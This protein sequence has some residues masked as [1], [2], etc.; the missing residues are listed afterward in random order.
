MTED[1]GTSSARLGS[2]A[3]SVGED[4][5]RFASTHPCTAT[6]FVLSGILF[7]VLPTTVLVNLHRGMDFSDAGYYYASI[8]QLDQ[9]GM[10]TTQFGT[11][12]NL[13]H[14]PES[15]VI[16]RAVLFLLLML[17]GA[18]LS[19]SIIRL[20]EDRFQDPVD[21]AL[22]TLCSISAVATFYVHW[23]P[24]PS[25]NSI[26]YLLNILVMSLNFQLVWKLKKAEP[27]NLKWEASTLGF[28]L[29]ALALT[30]PPTASMLAVHLAVVVLAVGRPGLDA[31]KRMVLWGLVGACG[32][33]LLTSI[34]VEPITATLDRIGGGLERRELLA[35]PTSLRAQFGLLFVDLKS[36]LATVILPI[37]L[38]V[39]AGSLAPQPSRKNVHRFASRIPHGLLILAVCI[40]AYELYSTTNGL[41]PEHFGQLVGV[42]LAIT[43]GVLAIGLARSVVAVT[44]FQIRLPAVGWVATSLVFAQF[45]QIVGTTSDWLLAFTWFNGLSIIAFALIIT[46][47]GTRRNTALAVVSFALIGFL[48]IASLNNMRAHPYR[49]STDLEAQSVRTEIRNTGNFVW[50]DQG[51]HRLLRELAGIRPDTSGGKPAPKI[52]DLTGRLPLVGY[53]LRGGIPGSTWLPSGYPGSQQ[54]FD[55]AISQLSDEELRSAWLIDTP[56]LSLRYNTNQFSA[57]AVELDSYEV[58]LR[59]Y[60]PYFDTDIVVWVPA[61]YGK[62]GR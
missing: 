29:I 33:V 14:L 17:S 56:E 62:A 47:L 45:S 18:L 31:C 55:H 36:N 60:Y 10:Q 44:G 52:L 12:W 1:L 42:S 49:Y 28:L 35:R 58:A 43:V 22:L 6:V 32:F 5:I 7:L 53:H 20:C 57:R 51:T 3:R 61:A 50:L 16:N 13:L 27:V 19:R 30:R 15:I 4:A 39:L 54:L 41:K 2:R 59:A 34:L 40:P 21:R 25:Y 8:Y 11:V 38:L 9:I 23:I 26:G 48:E 37:G 24:D 46:A